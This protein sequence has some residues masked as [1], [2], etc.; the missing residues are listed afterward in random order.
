MDYPGSITTFLPKGCVTVGRN[1]T[2]IHGG[3]VEGM[4]CD[5]VGVVT[6]GC[7]LGWALLVIHFAQCLQ[8][9]SLFARLC[10]HWQLLGR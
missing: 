2:V 8:F 1:L 10:S 9:S 4:A 3:S 5:V 7:G 6:N